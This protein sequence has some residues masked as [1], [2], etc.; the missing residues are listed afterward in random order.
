MPRID[1]YAEAVEPVAPDTPAPRL[2]GRF[3]AD[4]GL[5]IIPV[6]EGDRVLGL[7]E[8]SALLM[9]LTISPASPLTAS[10]LMDPEPVV[11]DG[12][13]S[14]RSLSH[15]LLQGD[16][17]T[18]NRGFI[19]TVAGRYVGV[20]TSSTLLRAL[21]EDDRP[22]HVV[23]RPAIPPGPAQAPGQGQVLTMIDAELRGPI[24]GILAVSE[25]LQ[26]QPLPG[27]SLD[28]VR[29]ITEQA[30]SLLGVLQDTRELTG[31]GRPA[32]PETTV[33]RALFDD[34][35]ASWA[36]RTALD[37]V[38]LMVGYEGDTEL[39]AE[40]DAERLRRI[41]DTLIGNALKYAREGMVEARLKA[42]VVGSMIHMSARVRD[43]G[44][45][46]GAQDLSRLFETPDS[47]DGG[48]SLSVCRR[49]VESLDGRIWA[50]NNAGR[51]TTISFELHAPRSEILLEPISRSL[52]LQLPDQEHKP[53][54]LIVDDNATNRVVAQALCEMFG[55][56][57]ETAEDG[58]EALEAV[59]ARP[60]DLILMDIKMPRMDGVQATLAIRALEPPLSHLPIIALTA[61]ADPADA[62]N[63]I[64]SGMASVVE[65]PIK[66]ERLRAAMNA[67]LV[68]SAPDVDDKGSEASGRRV[69]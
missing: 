60:F 44:P 20:G 8:R 25:L 68:N 13:I 1:D 40:I 28:H 67:A 24:N 14:A 34:I 7:L 35:E 23:D 51:G 37:G 9:R 43:D 30:Q 64:A 52:H 15:I 45:R 55:C 54:I 10:Q 36:A 31:Q 39:A 3:D 41:F 19:V 53:H 32:R 12:A 57:C 26:R 11:V 33:L 16:A 17:S 21:S 49:L 46:V 2:L 42:Q 61:N 58:I 22:T 69:A 27:D 6:L 48:F 47:M 50:E 65:K 62:A 29:S 66:P 5:L 59:Q 38:T 4:P 63:Y 18:L 56:S